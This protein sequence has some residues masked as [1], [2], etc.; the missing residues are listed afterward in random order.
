MDVQEFESGV[1][2][3][4]AGGLGRRKERRPTPDALFIVTSGGS[5]CSS[6]WDTSPDRTNRQHVGFSLLSYLP[7]DVIIPFFVRRGFALSCSLQHN[8]G[9][10]QRG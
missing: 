4:K 9:G 8:P 1:G 5:L 3:K 2:G 7:P 6:L 10:D